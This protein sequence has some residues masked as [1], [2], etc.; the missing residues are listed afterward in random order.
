M[1]LDSGRVEALTGRMSAY[2]VGS[3]LRVGGAGSHP[4]AGSTRGSRHAGP[5][6]VSWAAR[7]VGK[8]S[9]AGLTGWISA[10]ELISNKNFFLF[11]IC[12]INYKSI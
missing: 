1:N 4:V 10:Q 9:Q 6:L 12:F 5:R 3:L 7:K 11:Q 2:W 8:A